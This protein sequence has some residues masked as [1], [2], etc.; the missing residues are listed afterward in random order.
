M[1]TDFT[2]LDVAVLHKG[3][4]LC[5]GKVE[6][7]QLVLAFNRDSSVSLKELMLE[8]TRDGKT[9]LKKDLESVRG[10][11]VRSLDQKGP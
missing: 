1:K 6:G 5:T 9:L 3:K 10:A 2:K 7:E 4:R 8:I 11:D